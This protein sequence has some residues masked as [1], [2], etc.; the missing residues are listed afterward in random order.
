VTPED[1]EPLAVVLPEALDRRCAAALQQTLIDG[2]DGPAIALDGSQVQSADIAGI[3]LL[4]ALVVAAE[5]A[6]VA[7]GWTS[8]SPA[9]VTCVQR[10][11]ADG[12]VCLAGVRQEGMEWFD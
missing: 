10:L 7:L 2:L 6:G 12:V 8:V 11:G 1:A 3:Q 4:C 9:L 5:R